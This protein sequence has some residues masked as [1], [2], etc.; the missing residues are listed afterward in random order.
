[1]SV[2]VSVADYQAN[3]RAWHERARAGEVVVVTDS[4]RPSVR[5]TAADSESVLD[6]LEREGRLRRATRPRRPASELPQ[7]DAPGDSTPS[8]MAAR[9][10]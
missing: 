1:M 4:G 5:V 3:L 7:I 2:E 10:R 6:R 9:E 8:I